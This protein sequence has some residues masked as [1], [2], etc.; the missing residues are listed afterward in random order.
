M[1][2]PYVGQFPEVG[3]AVVYHDERGLPHVAILTAV[4]G[5]RESCEQLPCVNLVLASP[6]AS[7]QDDYGRQIERKSSCS[8]LTRTTAHGN[9]WRFQEET[10]RPYTPGQT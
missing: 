3:G 9:Y 4:W 10:P 7:K 5:Q 1:P 8:H 2:V 6:D